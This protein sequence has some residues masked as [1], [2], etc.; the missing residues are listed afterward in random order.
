MWGDGPITAVFVYGFFSHIELNWEV[1]PLARLFSRLGRSMRVVQFD[2]RGT[3]LSDRP[4]RPLTLEDRVDDLLAVIDTV[5]LETVALLGQDDGAAA[6]IVAAAGHPDRISHLVL[7][8]PLVRMLRSDDFPWGTV[9]SADELRAIVDATLAHWGDA[10]AGERLSRGADRA[11]HELIARYQRSA[12]SPRGYRDVLMASLDIDVRPILPILSI[13]TMVLHSA[14]TR[15]SI[16]V[17]AATSPT[18]SG[19]PD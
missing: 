9:R 12:I 14:P 7:Y 17:R 16:S 18:T 19:T 15:S 4:D 13:P 3:G 11:D 10:G 2:R 1:T 5:G 6:S 8:S